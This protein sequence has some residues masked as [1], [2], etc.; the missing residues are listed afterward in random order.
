MQSEASA[1]QGRKRRLP[2]VVHAY[3]I[4]QA[5]WKLHKFKFPRKTKTL[6]REVH[7]ASTPNICKSTKPKLRT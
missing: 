1:V 7:K 5:Y 3:V 2:Y 4:I 6:S